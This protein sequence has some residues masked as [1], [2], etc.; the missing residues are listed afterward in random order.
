MRKALSVDQIDKV[1]DGWND[2]EPEET[3]TEVAAAAVE[4]AQ[5]YAP[6]ADRQRLGHLAAH[7]WERYHIDLEK[8]MGLGMFDLSEQVFNTA[9]PEKDPGMLAAFLNSTML[10]NVLGKRRLRVLTRRCDVPG[11]R[12]APPIR[13]VKDTL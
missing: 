9:Q 8:Q 4:Y 5:M 7:D 6:H 3:D 10:G 1:A 12:E 13:S 11:A 2:E